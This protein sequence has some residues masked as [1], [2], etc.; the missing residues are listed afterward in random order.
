MLLKLG[1]VLLVLW[2]VSLVVSADFGDSR[3]LLLLLGLMM[4]LLGFLKARDAG[5]AA[6]R[7]SNEPTRKS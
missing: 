4:V 7:E 6:M 2:L 1:L 5:I 3:H